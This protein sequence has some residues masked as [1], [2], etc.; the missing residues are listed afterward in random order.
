MN[1][2][3]IWVCLDEGCNSSCHGKEWAVNAAARLEKCM[4]KQEFDWVHQREKTFSCLL[5]TSPSPR[6]TE[7]S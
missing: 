7:R 4:I 1:D 5:Y 3:G 6:D 2:P